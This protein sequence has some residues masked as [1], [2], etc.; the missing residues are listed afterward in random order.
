MFF[1]SRQQPPLLP[2]VDHL[3]ALNYSLDY[4]PET[5]RF[6]RFHFSAAS[7]AEH[8]RRSPNCFSSMNIETSDPSNPAVLNFSVKKCID[9]YLLFDVILP[10]RTRLS[11]TIGCSAAAK[12]APAPCSIRSTQLSMAGVSCYEVVANNRSRPTT[13]FLIRSH[14][15]GQKPTLGGQNLCCFFFGKLSWVN[16]SFNAAVLNLI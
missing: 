6:F 9:L 15:M 8:S 1:V 13:L 5:S 3:V 14:T 11:V 4:T 10:H 7:T 2:N 16:Q 12:L